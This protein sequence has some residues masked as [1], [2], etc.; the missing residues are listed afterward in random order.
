MIRFA[1]AVAA[2]FIAVVSAGM[3]QEKLPEAAPT[4]AI[5]GDR[6]GMPATLM[7]A[8]LA[9]DRIAPLADRPLALS[10]AVV[11]PGATDWQAAP[12]AAPR[13]ARSTTPQ[14]AACAHRMPVAG[15]VGV[16]GKDAAAWEC[17]PTR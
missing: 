13:L 2:V 17:A 9:A 11:A 5:A 1:Y 8:T 15:R 4:P 7:P 6:D 16:L 3:L 10:V 14:G 12:M